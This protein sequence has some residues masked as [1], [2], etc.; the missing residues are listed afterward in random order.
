[1]QQ[2][3]N[4]LAIIPAYNEEGSLQSTISELVSSV[5]EIDFIVINDGSRDDT[6]GVCVRNGYPCIHMPVNV[7]LTVAFQTGMKY[8]RR[9]NYSHAIQ[10]DADGQHDPGCI[11]AMF[12]SAITT[13][14]DIVI[15]SRF[16]SEKRG[17][18]ARMIGSRLISAMIRL[19]TGI[20]IND[21]TSGMRLYNRRM[22]EEF[23]ANDDLNPEPETLALMIRKGA[24]VQEVQVMMR[25]RQAGESYLSVSK[26]IVYMIRTCLSIL[27]VQWFR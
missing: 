27:F 21:P 22:I 20:T 1:M 23:A 18:S 6:E 19:T 7:G 8:A 12:S 15:G 17:I 14:A 5:P 3:H 26:S 24:R 25:E 13:N 4:L 9:H 10:F 2:G 11:R 16:V